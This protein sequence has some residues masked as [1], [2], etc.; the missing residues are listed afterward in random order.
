MKSSRTITRCLLLA[1]ALLGSPAGS[2]AQVFPAPGEPVDLQMVSRIRDEGLHRSKVMETV[3]HLTDVIGP[4]L[5]GSPQMKAANDWTRDK[6]AEW[7]L[8]NARLE[9][10]PFGR[11]WTY[12]RVAVHMV[13]P[14]Q[15]PLF[16]L[17]KGW[18]PGT[19]GPVR[20]PVVRVDIQS[21]KDFE[22]YRGKLAGKIVLRDPVRDVTDR[23]PVDPRR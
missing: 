18:T 22:T 15:V 12:S 2:F 8:A 5:T 11:G 1:A 21:E 3:E 7:G 10:W 20:A 16:S 13:K 9:P 14:H 17:P 23:M 6:L 4:R 19:N